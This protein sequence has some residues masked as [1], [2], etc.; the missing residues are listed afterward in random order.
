MAS[1]S[2]LFARKRT[3]IGFGAFFAIELILLFLL[4]LDRV[5]RS[6]RQAIERNRLRGG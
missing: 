2:K 5:E 1:S 3:Y 4:R 6:I